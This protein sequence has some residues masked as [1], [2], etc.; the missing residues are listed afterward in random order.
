MI[1]QI[2]AIEGFRFNAVSAGIKDVGSTRLDLALIATEAPAVTVGLTT[3]NLV[4]AAPVAV[5]RQHLAGG[6]CSAILMNSGNANAYTGRRGMEAAL[7]LTGSV[8]E[9]LDVAPELVIPMSTGV[10]GNPMPTERIMQRIPALVN[11]L[12]PEK[13]MDVARAIM[14]TD[15]KPI[16]VGRGVE[17]SS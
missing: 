6:R 9:C 8:A 14:T 5:T 3:T 11:G 17:L 15:T 10:I 4:Y 2:C 13:L 7:Q 1:D 12:A 16:S